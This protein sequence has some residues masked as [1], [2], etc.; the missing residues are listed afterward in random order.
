[1]S[2]RDYVIPR[3]DK[4]VV[5][6]RNLKRFARRQDKK[7]Y[8]EKLTDKIPHFLSGKLFKRKS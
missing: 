1:M 7:Y 2:S 4:K 3:A 6:L 8:V 5:C